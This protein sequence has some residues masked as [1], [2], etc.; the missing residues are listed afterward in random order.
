MLR[1]V[2]EDADLLSPAHGRGDGVRPAERDPGR[3]AATH[4]RHY[5]HL[6]TLLPGFVARVSWDRA[7]IEAHQL[8]ELRAFIADVQT[9]SPW[10]AARLAHLDAATMTI[11]DL[12]SV[13]DMTKADLMANWDQIVTVPGARL[14]SAEM[15]LEGLKADDYYLDTN[16]LVS[17]GG[18]S[19]QTGVLLYDWDGFAKHFA[20]VCRGH[21]PL[22]F[23]IAPP[24]VLRTASVG[25]DSA[26][27]ISY[28][29]S[30]AFQ[31][32]GN[33]TVRAPTTLPV[34]TIVERLNAKQP[35]FLHSYPSALAMLA[36]KA[37]AGRLTIAP[38]IVYS[39]SEPLSDELAD[40]LR[41]LW[42]CVVL[43]CWSAT[44]AS[45]T[46]P[47]TGDAA[48]HVSEDLNL[49]EPAPGDAAGVLVTNF[50]NRALPL[51]R[52]RIEDRFEFMD[53]PCSCGSAFRAVRSV[54]GRVNSFFHFPGGCAVSTVV[55][56]TRMIATPGI[57][58]W[59]I[60]QTA[61]GADVLVEQAGDADLPGLRERL[62]SALGEA[63]L[64]GAEVAVRAVEKIE[65]TRG[66]KV[67]RFVEVDEESNA[68]G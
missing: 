45:G 38:T 4:A 6:M 1:D 35:Q 11:A 5:S 33:P 64:D 54:A 42:P 12:A 65:R 20:G 44:E 2:P 48:F 31:T 39:S 55:F 16:H 10:H 60:R 66:G 19:G 51:I 49:I 52:Y 18:S 53:R 67:R 56:E 61:R 62:Q 29:C 3:I 21:I 43:N 68:A 26:K 13:P 50:Y 30:E 58:N 57:V 28:A 9:R 22:L 41:G 37:E 27:H 63:G 15:F 17:S 34:A 32:T 23:G 14:A 7:A 59:Q 25:A 36:R 46:F 8:A 24:T 40:R 47:C